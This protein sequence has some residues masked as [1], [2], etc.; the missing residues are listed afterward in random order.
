MADLP[1]IIIRTAEER[2]GRYLLMELPRPEIEHHRA[3]LLLG[4]AE[5]PG[6]TKIWRFPTAEGAVICAGL[7]ARELAVEGVEIAVSPHHELAGKF[8]DIRILTPL[9]DYHERALTN[10]LKW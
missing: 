9:A 8:P 7:R 2:G 3:Q 10:M 1:D 6:A 5:Q 4:Q